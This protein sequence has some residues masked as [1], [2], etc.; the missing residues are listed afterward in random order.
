MSEL[1]QWFR[2]EVG[3]Y[4]IAMLW[5]F[6]MFFGVGFIMVRSAADSSFNPVAPLAALLVLWLWS[7]SRFLRWVDKVDK[8][9]GRRGGLH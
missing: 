1:R 8:E 4:T 7:F 5:P 9:E 3:V 2:S 6:V